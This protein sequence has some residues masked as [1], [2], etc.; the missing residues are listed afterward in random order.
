MI[1]ILRNT[2]IDFMGKRKI[3]LV[4]SSI[5]IAI[6][7]FAVVQIARGSANLGIDFAGGTAVQIKFN[8]SVPLQDVREALKK[9]GIHDFDL[10]DLPSENKILIRIKKGEQTLG[11]LSKEIISILSKKFSESNIVVDSTTEVG[12][13][14]GARL[15]NDAF[16]AI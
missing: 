9:G 12:P 5:L 16:W 3:A 13:K 10:Q 7:L 11:N 2:K 6:G 15:R 14:V 1:E 8:E 4:F